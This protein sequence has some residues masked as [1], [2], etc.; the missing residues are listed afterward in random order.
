MT[1]DDLVQAWLRGGGDLG[2]S[3]KAAWSEALAE[4][5]ARGRAPWP[6]FGLDGA[7]FAEALGLCLAHGD[8]PQRLRELQLTSLWLATAC[9]QGDDAAASAFVEL[10]KRDVQRALTRFADDRA[11][12]SEVTD[13]VLDK[14]LVGTPDEPPRIGAYRGRGDLGRW[15]RV[16]AVRT[17]V[18]RTRSRDRRAAPAGDR[19]LLEGLDGEDDP[20]LA[21]LKDRYRAEFR[22]AFEHGV[23]SLSDRDKRLLRERVVFGL[24]VVQIARLHDTSKSTA[25][26]WVSAARAAL[27]EAVHGY[28]REHLD[29]ETDELRSLMKL[30]STHM[31]ISVARILD[32]SD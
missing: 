29:V 18:D 14:L 16:A 5:V 28:L 4:A 2:P 10:H 9:A 8:P 6:T 12:R 25:A 11:F 21:H 13:E 17:A 30:A 1:Q 15:V 27:V 31:N 7:A 19:A 26:R 22:A 3:S 20:E 32:R 24:G 23:A